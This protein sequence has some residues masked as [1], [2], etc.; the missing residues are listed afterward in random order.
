MMGSV[1]G[2]AIK[3][4]LVPLPKGTV[5]LPGVTSRIPVA[6]R[7]D[8]SNLLSSLL[9]RT[10]SGQRDGGS[11]TFG[12]VPLSSPFLSKDGQQ[13]LEDGN[14]NDA[15]REEYEAVDAGQAR[16]EDLFRH[17]TFGKVIGVQRRI[18]AEPFLLVQGVQ[19]FTIKRILKE[20]PF[21]EADVVL[22][23]EKGGM[24]QCLYR[25]TSTDFYFFGRFWNQ[26]LRN[27]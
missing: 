21:F 18:Y 11:I 22:H 15:Q 8:L 5:L 14:L 10:S 23:N 12:C 1:N 2:G 9:D 17:G 16:K 3:I 27:H 4:A 26:Q 13:L 7:P 25:G 24:N 6:N 20:R 19:R